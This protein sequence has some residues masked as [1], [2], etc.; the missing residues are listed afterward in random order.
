[1]GFNFHLFL[2]LD[3]FFR[4]PFQ[5]LSVYYIRNLYFQGTNTNRR[6]PNH[7]G[8]SNNCTRLGFAH[9]TDLPSNGKPLLQIRSP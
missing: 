7:D 5:A 8:T 1:M 6:N 9:N 4:S 3:G 2:E